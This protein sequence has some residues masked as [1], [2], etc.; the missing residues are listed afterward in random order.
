MQLY[1]HPVSQHARRVRIL[2]HELGLKPEEKLLALQEGEH[3]TEA[4]LKLNPAGQIPVLIDGDLVLPESHVI[5]KHLALKHGGEAFY[6]AEHRQQIDRWLDWTHGTLNPPVQSMAIEMFTNGEK[7][8]QDLIAGLHE[9][10]RTVLGG[11]EAGFDLQDVSLADFA[12]GTTLALYQMFG[13]SFDQFSRT[14]QRFESLMLRPS[15]I[16]TA[17][18][19]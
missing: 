14:S 8:N 6:P 4:F 12:I 9:R 7:A 17:P 18:E 1:S 2:C 5:M 16:A 11:C 19:M 3:K 10:V 15:F 13:G